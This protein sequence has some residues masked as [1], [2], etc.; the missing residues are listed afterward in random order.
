MTAMPHCPTFR[1]S[2]VAASFLGLLLLGPPAF[3]A[4]I[5]V[6]A[7][8]STIQEA[9]VAAMS[10][11]VVLV[12]PGT[13][14]EDIKFIGRAITVRS[15]AGPTSTILRPASIRAAD[16]KAGRHF[17]R[18]VLADGH[19]EVW[20][21]VNDR[22]VFDSEGRLCGER[23]FGGND[24]TVV[25]FAN[26]ETRSTVLEGFTISGGDAFV[27]GG[28]RIQGA[29]PTVRNNVISR[30]TACAAGGGIFV[31]AGSPLIEQ[32]Q[33]F[34]NRASSACSGGAGGGIEVV[35][36]NSAEMRRN[37]IHNNAFPIGAGIDLFDAG[38]PILADNEI[39]SNLA[40]TAGGGIEINND[41]DALIVQNI[42]RGNLGAAGF[43]HGIDWVVPSGHRGPF[44]L[45]NT[46]VH[47]GD[48]ELRADGFD[49]A[50]QVVGNVIVASSGGTGI[51]CD[52][53]GD[54][55]P[56]L[57]GS[58]NVWALGGTTYGGFCGNPTGSNG[59]ISG[60]PLFVSAAL[61]NLRLREG[62]PS[63]DAG[64]NA[65]P[66]LPPWDLD[67]FERIVDGNG[68]MVAVVDQGAYE[69]LAD[70]PV[71]SDGFEEGDTLAW[72]QTVP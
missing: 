59:N 18:R 39:Y 52:A 58:N 28:I 12:S 23:I 50:A 1:L 26:E 8:Y 22:L 40:V 46:I 68:D 9:I 35:G 10:G 69:R 57:I 37:M 60:D 3:A 44:L 63:V 48:R 34:D 43:G 70:M 61:G 45:N 33:I 31:F 65:H 27:G 51:F 53:T 13:Y 54:H 32:N 47:N 30:N 11:D 24:G 42:V 55:S 14:I 2:I 66:D 15:V 36:Q 67:L 62:S 19:V 6:P 7:D 16:S 72:S 25:L 56:P 29:S 71:F 64:D 21:R 5:L 17:E 4:T 41:S 38:T 20:D 49:A